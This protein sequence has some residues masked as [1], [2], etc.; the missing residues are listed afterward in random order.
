MLWNLLMCVCFFTALGSAWN[1]RASVSMTVR[2]NILTVVIGVVVG[3]V[4]AL[5]TDAVKNS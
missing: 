2:S 5:K 3:A 4:C 1:T